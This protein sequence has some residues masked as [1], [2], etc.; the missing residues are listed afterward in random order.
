MP[1]TVRAMTAVGRPT[2]SAFS[3][4]SENGAMDAHRPHETEERNL[5]ATDRLVSTICDSI[6]GSDEIIDSP[7]GP[8][9]VVYA[10]FAASGRSLRFIEDYPR[11]IVLPLYAN[12]HTE[13]SGTGLQTTRFRE[14]ARSIIASCVGA[15]DEHA[16][17]FC[18]SGA[19]SCH[20]RV[21]R[22]SRVA[23]PISR[24]PCSSLPTK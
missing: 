17:L 11:D 15:T 22:R 21:D 2:L 23:D 20:R 8:R 9:P 7:F 6:I 16:V 1:A 18:G 12:T 3:G 14:E 13:A 4:N 5:R 19:T 10:D 24:T